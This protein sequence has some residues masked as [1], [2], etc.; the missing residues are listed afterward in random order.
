M[1]KT[2]KSFDSFEDAEKA[3]FDFY[4]ALSGE[5]RL[6]LALEIMAASYAAHPR[7]ERVYRVVELSECPVLDSWRLGF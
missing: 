2:F 3:D 7:L 6:Q 4:A 1:D 5:E